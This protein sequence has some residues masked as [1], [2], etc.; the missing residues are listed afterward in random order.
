LVLKEKT[1]AGEHNADEWGLMRTGD[2]GEI[3]GG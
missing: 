3:V 2:G 1:E